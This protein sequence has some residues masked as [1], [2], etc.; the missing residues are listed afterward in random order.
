M[1]MEKIQLI[2]H[3]I[4][5]I[6]LS[7]VEIPYVYILYSNIIALSTILQHLIKTFKYIN[8]K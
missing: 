5:D 3:L 4:L 2:F 8:E 1:I 7:I 6:F